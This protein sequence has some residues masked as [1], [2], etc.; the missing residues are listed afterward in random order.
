[1]G[2][3]IRTDRDGV[4]VFGTY[5]GAAE[6]IRAESFFG[7]NQIH[8]CHK[9][10][11]AVCN[12]SVQAEL[13]TNSYQMMKEIGDIQWCTL[14]EAIAKIRPDNVEKREVLLKAGKIM[15]NFYPIFT[16]DEHR[17]MPNASKKYNKYDK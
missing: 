4:Q 9:Y 14:D 2:R 13:N 12:N 5:V 10:Y 15:R 8:Y 1:M 6:G 17:T 3:P 7:S 11:I 16:S